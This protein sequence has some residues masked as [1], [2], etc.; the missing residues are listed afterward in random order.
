MW[1]SVILAVAILPCSRIHILGL[2][3][4]C[5]CA[6]CLCTAKTFFFVQFS[7]HTHIF[8]YTRTHARTN[9]HTC[10]HIQTYTLSLHIQLC[11][12]YTY[13]YICIY[14]C[15]TSVSHLHLQFTTCRTRAQQPEQ[16]WR[17]RTYTRSA[18]AKQ[19]TFGCQKQP[20]G[21]TAIW[22]CLRAKP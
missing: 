21:N 16:P 20:V 19:M 1:E 22:P 11:I 17:S 5:L 13:V 12:N 14:H 6:R 8:M 15:V 10:I 3:A 9:T 18:L 4:R 2:H 7:A